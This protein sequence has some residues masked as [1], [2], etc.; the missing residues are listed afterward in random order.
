[1]L[2]APENRQVAALEIV[3]LCRLSAGQLDPLLWDET[4]ESRAE[5]DWDFSTSAQL[6]RKLIGGRALAGFALLDGAEVAGYVYATIEDRK[7]LIGNLYVRPSWRDGD[8]EASL[9]VSILD[10][11]IATPRVYRIESQPILMNRTAGQKAIQRERSVASFERSLMALDCGGATLPPRRVVGPR[12]HFQAWTD[13]LQALA[14]T[15]ISSAYRNHIDSWIN[16]QYR[17]SAGMLRVLHK[18]VQYPG[19]G[20]SRAGSFAA[21]DAETDEPAGI[22]L[23]SFI[24][25][26]VGHIS[27]LCVTE[28]ARGAGLGNELLTRAAEALRHQG[29]TRFNLNVTTANADAIRLY[30]RFGFR[31][32]RR[33]FAYV[34]ERE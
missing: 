28:N 5:L 22:V 30:E 29:A 8:A 3:D 31:E 15:V 26:E 18:L 6:I 19:C 7:G 9:F 23:A 34:W 20:F 12:F 27:E 4:V 24:A 25:K 33:F 14:A 17:S 32:T 21:F 13:D 1:M 10:A 16:D 2:A 11:L